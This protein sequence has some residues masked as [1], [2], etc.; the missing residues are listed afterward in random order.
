ME[1]SPQDEAKAL[2]IVEQAMRIRMVWEEVTAAHWG[3]PSREVK[4]ALTQAAN[5]WAVQLDERAATLTAI[6]IAGGSWE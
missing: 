5:R 1:G 3:R 2:H 4:D 6:Y